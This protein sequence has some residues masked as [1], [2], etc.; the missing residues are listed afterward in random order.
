VHCYLM[1][2]E[3]WNGS[4]K[5]GNSSK[6]LVQVYHSSFSISKK[7]RL[8][9]YND[10]TT[11][12]LKDRFL[13]W[14]GRR[15]DFTL[16]FALNIPLRCFAFFLISAHRTRKIHVYY[17][18]FLSFICVEHGHYA[19]SFS[20]YITLRAYV[21]RFACCLLYLVQLSQLIFSF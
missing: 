6:P 12:Y 14:K 2:W 18:S 21:L 20:A 15:S 19:T 7:Q 10:K 1:R 16:L 5:A 11:D 3:S 13:G 8:Y 4:A 9:D 17:F